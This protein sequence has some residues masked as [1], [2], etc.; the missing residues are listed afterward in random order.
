ML[1]AEEEHSTVAYYRDPAA[2]G[3]RPGEYYINTSQPETRPRYEAEALAFH[4]AVP[5]H[6]L[7]IALAQELDGPAAFRRERAATPPSSRA[8]ACTPSAW[9]TRWA[10]TRDDLDR[11]GHALATTPG[12]PAAWWS[13]PACT[14]SAGRAQQAI[15]FMPSTPP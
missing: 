10:S 13:T 1:A 9:P 3:S 15:D 7:Q 5:G 12:A 4:E 2:D 14:R 6:H 8:G 11:L